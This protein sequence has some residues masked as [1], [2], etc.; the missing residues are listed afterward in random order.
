MWLSL[1][2]HKILDIDFLVG[3]I[4][5]IFDFS[6]SWTRKTDHAGFYL[7]LYLLGV[8]FSFSIADTRHWND[9]TGTWEDCDDQ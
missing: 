3:E 9:K 6:I 1:T 8:W 5:D 7:D 4:V 2:K